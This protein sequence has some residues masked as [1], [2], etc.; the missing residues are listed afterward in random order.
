MLCFDKFHHLLLFAQTMS[1]K[2]VKKKEEV[3]WVI[4]L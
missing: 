4:K 2:R 3:S 1:L